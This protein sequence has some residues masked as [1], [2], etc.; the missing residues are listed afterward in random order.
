MINSF[1]IYLSEKSL[2]VIW[3]ISGKS[4]DR[5]LLHQRDFVISIWAAFVDLLKR[6]FRTFCFYVLAI[7]NLINILYVP[8]LTNMFTATSCDCFQR[9]FVTTNP[10]F[11]K[12][13]LNS[14]GCVPVLGCNVM[15]LFGSETSHQANILPFPISPNKPWHYQKSEQR[16][17]T[18]QTEIYSVLKC[19]IYICSNIYFLMQIDANRNYMSAKIDLSMY[20]PSCMIWRHSKDIL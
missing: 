1:Q 4:F 9:T 16:Q 3:S 20:E 15:I 12:T 13:F 2:N 11:F 18:R 7:T 17:T 8:L 10:G 19:T 6:D 5:G 14:W